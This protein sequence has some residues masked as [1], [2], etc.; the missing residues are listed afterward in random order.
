MT[1]AEVAAVVAERSP[2]TPS[3]LVLRLTRGAILLSPAEAVAII[4]ALLCDGEVHAMW[5][6]GSGR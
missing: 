5:L 3:M 4:A 2:H 6:H 1:P